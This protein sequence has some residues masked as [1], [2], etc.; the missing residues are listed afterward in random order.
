MLHIKSFFGRRICLTVTVVCLGCC[1]TSLSV[2]YGQ[3]VEPGTVI[4]VIEKAYGLFKM[5]IAYS[6]PQTHWRHSSERLR[7]RSSRRYEIRS[8]EP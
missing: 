7:R 8:Y 4:A 3:T 2:G 5:R 1:L 6:A